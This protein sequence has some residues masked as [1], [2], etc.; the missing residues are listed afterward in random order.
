MLW[1]V[2]DETRSAFVACVGPLSEACET[3]A[4]R[5]DDDRVMATVLLRIIQ[6]CF[7]G[8]R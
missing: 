8:V 1:L 3:P 4:D 2:G 6:G 7:T 5:V